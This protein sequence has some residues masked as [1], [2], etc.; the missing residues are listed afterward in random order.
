MD[1]MQGEVERSISHWLQ[2]V[3]FSYLS[4][5]LLTAWTVL[6]LQAPQCPAQQGMGIVVQTRCV[7][8]SFESNLHTRILH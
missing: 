8:V 6:W 4:L 5:S 3:L 2:F 1:K 7:V